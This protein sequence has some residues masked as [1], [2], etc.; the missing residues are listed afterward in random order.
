MTTALNPRTGKGWSD[1][2]EHAFAAIMRVGLLERL[3]AIRLYRRSGNDFLKALKV[4]K[5]ERPTDAELARRKA[6]SER[7][8]SRNL[9]KQPILGHPRHENRSCSVLAQ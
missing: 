9:G 5:Q 8:R 7:I 3:P 1:T 6:Q 2:E 4:A